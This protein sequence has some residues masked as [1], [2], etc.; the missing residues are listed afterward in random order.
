[1]RTNRK[2]KIGIRPNYSYVARALIADYRGLDTR[3]CGRCNSRPVQSTS[4]GLDVICRSKLSV[5]DSGWK[6]RRGR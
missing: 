5:S 6:D 1:M 3:K 2:L 4:I